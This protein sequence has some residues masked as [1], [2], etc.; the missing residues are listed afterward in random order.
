[1]PKTS[2]LIVLEFN[3]LTPKLMSH[4]IGE[5]LLPNF[6]KFHDESLVFTT[7]AAERPPYLEPWIQWVTTHTGVDYAE[8]Q[9]FHLNEGHK[10][11]LPRVW[12]LLAER[13]VRSWICGSMNVAQ[14]N[15]P[16]CQIVPDPWCTKVSPRPSELQTYFRFVQQNVLEHT[17]EDA[18]FSGADYLKFLTFMA[19]HGLSA[20]SVIRIL[21][22]LAAERR[23]DIKWRRV[24]LLDLLQY[25]VFQYY[26]RAF[27]PQFSTFF[28]NSTAHYQHAYWDSMDPDAF[29]SAPDEE[30]RRRYESAIQFG[31]EQMD[32]LLGRLM[33]MVDQETTLLLSTALSQ[34]PWRNHNSEGG[35]VFFRPKKL[36]ELTQMADIH[37]SYSVAPVMAEQFYLQFASPDAAQDAAGRL[38]RLTVDGESC[39]SVSCEGP[40][41]FG[42]C[43]IYRAVSEDAMVIMDDRRARFHDVFYQLQTSKSGVHNP[44]G[45][46]WMRTPERRHAVAEQKVPLRAVAPTVLRHFGVTPPAYMSAPLPVNGTVAAASGS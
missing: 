23:D 42:G 15:R 35:G 44:D 9:V 20:T 41:L 3:E 16:E 37:D 45:M 7:E 5:G 1:M 19:A 27:K 38:R 12:D 11:D 32:R 14:S 8:H 30:T 43:R 31:Y 17:N 4:F 10:L 40:R 18:A 13:G 46:L 21:R 33:A 24:V 28:L 2:S 39:L 25:D 29:S 6:K 34:E 26:Y 22:Q 36:E